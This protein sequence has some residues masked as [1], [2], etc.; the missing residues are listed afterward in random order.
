M[1]NYGDP[2]NMRVQIVHSVDWGCLTM[3]KFLV[4]QDTFYFFHTRRRYLHSRGLRA[5]RRSVVKS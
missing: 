2:V 5:A 3:E 4:A 1:G